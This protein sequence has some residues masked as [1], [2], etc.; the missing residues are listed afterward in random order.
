MEP[1]PPEK[2][3][4]NEFSDLTTNGV[5]PKQFM[6]GEEGA[7]WFILM[8]SAEDHSFDYSSSI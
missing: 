5:I 3:T 7:V 8:F 1:L 6:T 2:N 4:I